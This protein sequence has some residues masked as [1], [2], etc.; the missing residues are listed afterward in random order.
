VKRNPA[1]L[2]PV[3]AF[4]D[5]F[6]DIRNH[7][8]AMLA[9]MRMAYE[10]MLKRFDPQMLQERFDETGKRGS[11]LAMPARMRY[12]E[13]F[14]EHYR[15]MV[16]DPETSFRELFGAEFTRA[17]EEQLLRLRTLA[18]SQKRDS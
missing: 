18:R 11:L 12:W 3:D 6:A 16:K 4:E 7:Q 8:T 15:D 10:A 5:G 9:G 1:Y 2:G 14:S 17:Y 13:Q